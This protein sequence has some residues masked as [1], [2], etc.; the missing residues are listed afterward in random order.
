VESDARDWPRQPLR[1]LVA[2]IV[3]AYH[4]PLREE[5]PR[6]RAMAS[7]VARTHGDK[8]PHAAR[9]HA[10]LGEL[11]QD[12]LAH[13]WKEET[14]LFPAIEAPEIN[15]RQPFP[16]AP[17]IAMMENEHDHAGALLAEVRSLTGGYDVPEWGCAMVR[18]LYHGLAE[19]ELN[20]QAHVHLENNVLFPR[21]LG[22]A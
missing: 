9:L 1:A 2:H 12:L 22:N 7:T 21:A 8:A 11:S 19:L 4:Q 15:G 10:I 20:M 13:M 3:T 5:L 17:R 16:I 18:A 6:L 14:V